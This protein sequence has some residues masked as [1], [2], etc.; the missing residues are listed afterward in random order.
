LPADTII[1]DSEDFINATH[2]TKWVEERLDFSHIP[3]PGP[4]AVSVGDGTV[5]KDVVAEVNGR[6][7]NVSMWVPESSDDGVP[8]P[9]STAQKPRRQHQANTVGSGSGTVGAPM[10]G[11]IVKVNVEVGQSVEAGDTVCILEAMKMENTV[12]ASKA[13]VIKSISVK[14][15]DAVTNGDTICVIE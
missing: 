14:A 6:R 9:H 4:A 10:Q 15:G 2:S 5:R 13:G 7:V 12:L 11:T 1:L 3:A 8:K